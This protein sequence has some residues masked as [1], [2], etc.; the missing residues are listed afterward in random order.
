MEKIKKQEKKKFYIPNEKEREN[1]L[2]GDDFD[3]LSEQE[4][5]CYEL[6]NDFHEVIEKP[7]KDRFHF[8]YFFIFLFFIFYFK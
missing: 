4:K 5:K 3:N 7:K 2:K 1:A 8:F 6:G